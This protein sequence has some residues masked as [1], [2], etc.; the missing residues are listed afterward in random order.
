MVDK[1]NFARA[2]GGFGAGVQGQGAQFLEHLE[3]RRNNALYQGAYETLQLL[4]Q[5]NMGAAREAILRQ[6]ENANRSGLDPS[7][8]FATLK[9]VEAG[10]R[11]GAL[12]DVRAVVNSGIMNGYLKEQPDRFR[13]LTPEERINLGIPESAF[14]QMNERTRKVD[15]NAMSTMLGQDPA[16]TRHFNEMM[17]IINDPNAPPEA[18]NAA[19]IN[20]GI[21]PRAVADAPM[22]QARQDPDRNVFDVLS[23]R[24]GAKEGGQQA[25]RMGVQFFEKLPLIDKNIENYGRA[26]AALDAGAKS[27]RVQSLLPSFRAASIELDNMK[28][29]LGL[30]VVGMTTFGSLSKGELDLSLVTALPDHLDEA[31]LRDWLVRRQE[32]ERKLR[33]EYAMAA[34][35]L[36]QPGTTIGDYIK[37]M[38]DQG[39]ITYAKDDDWN[40]GFAKPEGFDALSPEEKAEVIEYMR[41]KGGN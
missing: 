24:E 33:A 27:G 41:S 9:K 16:Q 25:V 20:L 2:L 29:K 13:A 3:E 10:D 6:F 23:E 36:T 7:G 30:D 28:N 12:S 31:P 35:Y 4:E 5:D 15:I 11:D 37:M 34:A 40:E 18:K 26:I 32:A 38:E 1:Y 8:I 39:R 19:R 17:A 21:N 14:A 22:T